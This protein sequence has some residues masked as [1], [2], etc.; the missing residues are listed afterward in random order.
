M[1]A[2]IFGLGRSL[3]PSFSLAQQAWK[4]DNTMELRP[5]E[6]L[7][8]VKIISINLVSFSEIW[9]ETGGDDALLRS[10]VLEIIRARGK[11]HNP[12]TNTGGMLYGVVAGM[13]AAYPNHYGV[14]VGDEIISL[15]SLSITPLILTRILSVDYECA[16]MEVEGQAILYASSPVVQKPSDMPLRVAISAMDEAGAPARTFRTVERNQ[17]VL[18]LGASGRT[19]LLCGYAARDKMGESGRLVG[20]VRDRE[21]RDLLERYQLYDEV[22]ALDA[23]NVPRLV[24]EE[25]GIARQFDVVINCINSANT[26]LASLVAVKDK[27][28]VYFAS[29]GC[30]YKFAALTAES[31]GK[32]V[33]ILPYTGFLEGHAAYTLGLL[34]RFPRMRDALQQRFEGVEAER[35]RRQQEEQ[36]AE[37]HQDANVGGYIFRSKESKFVLRQALKVARYSSNVMVCG[38]SGVGKE[39]IAR[40]IHQNSER[41][42][43]PMVKINCAAIPEPLLESELFGYEKGSFTG[44]GAKGKHG[45]WETAQNGTLFLDEVGELPLSI[46]A[47]L[48]RVI[49][50][51]EIVR[52]GGVTPIKVN[53]RLIAATNRDLAEMV[54]QNRFREDLY[55]RL[56]VYPIT[57]P[58]LRRRRADIVPLA[59]HF[60]Q[61]YNR[62]FGLNKAL[63][64]KTLEFLENQPFPGNIRELQNLIQRLMITTDFQIIEVRDVLAALAY[65][66]K[67]DHSHPAEKPAGPPPQPFQEEGLSLKELL[68][69]QEEAILRACRKQYRSTREMARA[70][71]ISQP[72]VVRKLNQYG[73]SENG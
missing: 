63:G 57:V 65:D 42:S 17:S 62:E 8:Q 47:K 72:S 52:V 1:T 15:V 49:Q 33:T 54:R 23:T 14:Q 35:V 56:N 28:T 6:L 60:I 30:D 2:D 51:K 71:Q 3:E 68:A 25:G 39:I 38:E 43:F 29:L 31:I 7:V 41:K 61:R 50:E 55:Y 20:L 69:R 5:G 27:G 13:G 16:Q 26:E 22:L 40:I 37:E 18:V 58:P 73:I 44:A 36:W 45:L 11:L 24:E 19:G 67:E 21:S 46:Q 59:E 70:L 10:R 4:V 32:E 9:E 66:Q 48:L 64:S 12:V 34:R 53:V